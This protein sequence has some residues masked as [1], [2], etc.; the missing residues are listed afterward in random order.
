MIANMWHKNFACENNVKGEQIN[1]KLCD[2]Y[3]NLLMI[4]YSH[5]K[6]NKDHYS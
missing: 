4:I 3:Y 1:D 2:L 6:F 5:M